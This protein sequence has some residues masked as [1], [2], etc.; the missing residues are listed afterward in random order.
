MCDMNAVENHVRTL[1]EAN[2]SGGDGGPGLALQVLSDPAMAHGWVAAIGAALLA[3]ALPG[4][5]LWTRHRPA[6]TPINENRA[7]SE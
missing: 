3:L 5:V 4:L 2:T 1:V 7:T 6:H